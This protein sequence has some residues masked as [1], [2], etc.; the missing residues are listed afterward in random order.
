[1]FVPVHTDLEYA[2]PMSIA[3]IEN[4]IGRLNRS[5]ATSANGESFAV[6]T[7][8]LRDAISVLEQVAAQMEA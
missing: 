2:L 5:P 3:S 7:L 6:H 1:M 8:D 4:L